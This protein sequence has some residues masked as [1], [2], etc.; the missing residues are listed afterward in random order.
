MEGADGAKAAGEIKLFRVKI[1]DHVQGGRPLGARNFGA[2]LDQPFSDSPALSA[3]LDEQRLEL[4]VA[5]LTRQNHGK[6]DDR[7]VL[8]HDEYGADQNLLER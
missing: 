8:F 2:M 5:V 4:R 3:G 7:A 1:A 6:T